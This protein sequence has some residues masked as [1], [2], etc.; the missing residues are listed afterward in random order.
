MNEDSI[1]INT[2][3]NDFNIDPSYLITIFFCLYILTLCFVVFSLIR[4]RF[5][6]STKIN[7]RKKSIVF[8]TITFFILFIIFMFLVYLVN[9][10]KNI[11]PSLG[12]DLTGSYW[13]IILV[14]ISNLGVLFR[15]TPIKNYSVINYL[16]TAYNL[17]I[18]I[19]LIIKILSK[20]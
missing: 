19:D 6:Q 17:F 18:S 16:F 3:I 13:L 10:D 20:C 11:C 9:T 8:L 2:R 5:A 1:P 14:L 12:K 4:R 15:N 7:R